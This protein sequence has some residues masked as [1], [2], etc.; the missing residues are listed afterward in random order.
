[1]KQD[2]TT[3]SVFKTVIQFS[4]PFLLSYF[5]QTLYGMADLFIIGQFNGVDSTTAVSI[6]SQVMHMLTVMIVGLA[7]G[8]TV[9]IGR[10]IGSHKQEQAAQT[11][12]NTITLFMLLSIL[13][14]GILLLAV[15][16][17]VAVMS[18]PSE[19][20]SGTV[21][22]LTICFIGI[23]FIT[24]YNII[25][26]IFRGM[27]DSK[28]PMYFI[29]VS[30]AANI[31][32]DYLFIGTCKLNAAGA[33]LGT[34]LSQT[35]SVIVAL[36]VI[37]KQKTGITL[38]AENFKPHREIMHKLLQIG[39]PVALQ[40][41]FI[42]ISFIVITVIANKRGLND[43]AAVGIVEKLI[44][45]MFL[46]P[47][48]MLSTVS[49]LSSQNIGAGKHERARLTLRY[50]IFIA[51]A[52]GAVAIFVMQIAAEPFVSLFVDK[53]Q[54]GSLEVIRLG[55]EYMRGY[56]WDCLFAG[57][58]F[59]FSGYFCAYGLSMIPFIHNSISIICARIPLSYLASRYFMDTLF[60]MG[61]A[62]PAGSLL[63]VFICVG[64][65][66]WMKKRQNI[67]T[68]EESYGKKRMVPNR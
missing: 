59:S 45:I 49:A 66:I 46:I 24:A 10:A 54:K 15:K 39:V 60:P 21:S 48:S 29:A 26:S 2:L 32:L 53:T 13:L 9:M 52:W 19:A 58:T 56:V 8:A 63:S 12:G 16:P 3:G 50:A 11:I 34:T 47:S 23:P 27:G 4:L 20:V 57:I 7:M 1:M 35:I 42:Q 36:A 64:V 40:E 14:A 65:F 44:G 43:A 18:T 41:G 55:G 31:V 68:E 62:S 28:S 30:C 37:L 61:L 17:I 6:G 38:T 5:L 67:K 33:A 51:M 22:Y 25:S